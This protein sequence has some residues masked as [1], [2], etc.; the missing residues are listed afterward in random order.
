[1]SD[2]DELALGPEAFEDFERT[3]SVHR[4]L[5]GLAQNAEFGCLADRVYIAS[6]WLAPFV[7][8]ANDLTPLPDNNDYLPEQIQ[9]NVAHLEDIG[10]QLAAVGFF[11]PQILYHLDPLAYFV[12]W[13]DFFG[14]IK[15]HVWSGPQVEVD[16]L[17]SQVTLRH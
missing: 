15:G 14:R 3:T 16:W 11:P 10:G 12:A 13:A 8:L 7:Q 4:R 2:L 17:L 1:M 9:L 6:M 5:A